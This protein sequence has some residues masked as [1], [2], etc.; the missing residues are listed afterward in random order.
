MPRLF[1]LSQSNSQALAQILS[2]TLPVWISAVTVFKLGE[3]SGRERPVFLRD[4]RH[5]GT[6]VED[7]CVLGRVAF[8]EEDNVCLDA[9]TVRR[10]CPAR[11]TQDRMHVAIVHQYLKH[12]A[13]LTF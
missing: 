12:L 6:R 5:I 13:R 9:L 8:L 4:S 2:L 11:Q 1:C 7:P 3:V 10:E